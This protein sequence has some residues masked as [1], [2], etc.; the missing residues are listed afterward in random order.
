MQNKCS[1]FCRAPT[2][3]EVDKSKKEEKRAERKR[4]AKDKVESGDE[5]G[6]WEHVK[7]GAHMIKVKIQIR[8]SY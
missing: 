4:E 5:E 7:G 8:I 6:E 3:I 2:E 1:Y